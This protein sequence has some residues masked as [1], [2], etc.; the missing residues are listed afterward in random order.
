MKFASAQFRKFLVNIESSLERIARG[1]QKCG[2]LG[3]GLFG[4][5]VNPSRGVVPSHFKKAQV[6]PVPK[7][8]AILY[9]NI[10]KYR[11]ISQLPFNSKVLE[12][13]V[14]NCIPAHLEEYHLFDKYQSAYRAA[15]S[16]ETALLRVHHDITSAPDKGSTVA[17]VMLDQSA[18][19]DVIAHDILLQRLE[20]AFGISGRAL[21]WFGS[22]LQDRSQCV[23][24]GKDVSKTLPVVCRVPQ[25]SVLGPLLYTMYTKSIG[26]I[27]CRHNVLYYCYV[28]DIQLYCTAESSKDLAA[29]LSSTNECI[30]ELKSWMGYN[31][32]KRNSE[33]KE[34]IFAS[35]KSPGRS[36]TPSLPWHLRDINIYSHVWSLG[37]IFDS[38]L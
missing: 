37:V 11:P 13:V 25:G 5:C 6:T 23:C 34:F 18:T 10:S 20:F 29:K 30:G 31:M 33:K 16:T 32:L 19:F 21:K 1:T 9:D 7:S 22:Y 14:T 38:A 26:K 3:H 27:C 35:K 12:R 24:V 4:L 15:H 2:A 8:R 17:L 28:D 36:A